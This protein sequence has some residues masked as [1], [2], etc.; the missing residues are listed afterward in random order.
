[1]DYL[2]QL[3]SEVQFLVPDTG[4]VIAGILAC[5]LLVLS[6]YASGSEIAFFSLSP[7]DLN[8]LD[9]E[10]NECDRQIR[11]LRADS[12]RTLATILITNNCKPHLTTST[13]ISL[14]ISSLK[15]IQYPLIS[16]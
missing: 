15:Q 10:K 1:M 9:E 8:D 3:F 5:V 4:A 12:E 7:N 2:Q 14:A 13:I 16:N 11:E 6:G